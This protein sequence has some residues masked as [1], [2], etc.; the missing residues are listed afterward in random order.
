[1]NKYE[2][3]YIV[4][5]SLS[6]EDKEKVVLAVKDVVEKAGGKCEEPDR[7]QGYHHLTRGGGRVCQRSQTQV[8]AQLQQPFER[9]GCLSCLQY[10][11]GCV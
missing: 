7:W 6:D 4:D 11:S 2:I 9:S 5:A 10:V 8:S 1:M 3:L